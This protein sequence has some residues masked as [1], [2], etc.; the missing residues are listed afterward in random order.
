MNRLTMSLSFFGC[1]YG[2]RRGGQRH[3]GT[4][5]GREARGKANQGPQ[6]TAKLM[7]EGGGKL[8]TSA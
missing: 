6:Q 8:G 7:S 5:Q 2:A 1:E 4:R 3:S